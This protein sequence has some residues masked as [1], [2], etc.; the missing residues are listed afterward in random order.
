MLTRLKPLRRCY[1]G[2]GNATGRGKQWVRYVSWRHELALSAAKAS[3]LVKYLQQ[4]L[5]YA[6]PSM[7]GSDHHKYDKTI[8]RNLVPF[9]EVPLSS[10]NVLRMGKKHMPEV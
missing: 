8:Q 5:G 10:L 3:H 7:L 1:G 4:V 9:K 2:E 6:K